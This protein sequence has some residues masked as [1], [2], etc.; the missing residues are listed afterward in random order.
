LDVASLEEV[1]A[2]AVIAFR[3]PDSRMPFLPVGK[4]PEPF[5]PFAL[6]REHAGFVPPVLH[7][8][9]R[10]PRLAEAHASLARAILFASGALERTRK[11]EI[12][13]ASAAAR[14]DAS[15]AASHGRSL[16]F[17]GV[18][19]VRVEAVLR[20]TGLPADVS[21]LIDF[22]RAL[23]LEP[24][25]TGPEDCRILRENG[26]S[27][28]QILETILTVGLGE[29]LRVLVAGL[30]ADPEPPPTTFPGI[31]DR[32][33]ERRP[34]NPP[35]R[36]PEPRLRAPARTPEDF[37]P[38]G[39][40]RDNLG[41]VP[42]LFQAQTLHPAAL[43]AEADA[44]RDILLAGDVLTRLQKALLALAVSAAQRHAY[45]V[46]LHAAI[47][48]TLGVAPDL[49]DRIIEDPAS[50]GLPEED[51]VLLDAASRL[52]ADPAKYGPQDVALLRR[53]GFRDDQILEAVAATAFTTFLNVVQSGLGAKPD[54][55]VRHDFRAEAEN[56]NP[57][58]SADRPTIDG[59]GAPD[60]SRDP[61]AADVA[62][63]R[64][65]DMSA[66][67]AL[68]RRH[69]G[70]VYRTLAGVT[71]SSDEA[72]DGTQAVFVKVF[73]KIGDF[74]GGSLFSTWLTRIAIN[75]G[76]ERLRRRRPV[77]SLEERDEAD[78]RPTRLQP[79]MDDPETRCARSEMRRLVEKALAR[80]PAPYRVAVLLRDIEQLSSAE[81]AA[82]AGVPVPTLKT[83]LLRGRLMMRE[84]LAAHFE[85]PAAKARGEDGRV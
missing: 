37:P 61:D 26:F 78:F 49:S 25:A 34:R 66:F 9:S 70:R 75:E 60:K 29:F 6:F 55:R 68:V 24:A 65:G 47:L 30:G 85:A 40:L 52:A 12:L 36:E 59:E 58:G 41:F 1:S 22:S 46:T 8:E 73:R 35:S 38:F 27:D 79:W 54:F 20:G 57:P 17:L 14:S 48:R 56:L 23:A 62:R 7:A 53:H 74:E 80:L 72:E 11:E 3:R 4:P 19:P 45:G 44:L 15:L 51:G 43:E 13:L 76:L 5:P 69:Q 83:R 33:P 21:A 82:A 10:L 2:G 67:E 31:P 39:F 32:G 81:A 28:E 63:A 18:E 84:S 16:A 42:R 77:E 50:A 64:R 71:G